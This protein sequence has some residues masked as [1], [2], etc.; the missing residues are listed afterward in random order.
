MPKVPEMGSQAGLPQMNWLSALP[1]A[2]VWRNQRDHPPSTA[3]GEDRGATPLPACVQHPAV[4]T[5][6]DAGSFA[7][8]I[9]DAI[10]FSPE[11]RAGLRVYGEE[12][13]WKQ[14]VVPVL[15]RLEQLGL[16][17]VP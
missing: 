13:D 17:T 7:A 11:R 16:R 8:G 4:T 12:A 14:R 1:W 9:D 5:A 3:I 10:E 15:E 2:L 6:S